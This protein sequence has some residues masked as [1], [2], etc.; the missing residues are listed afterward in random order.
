MKRKDGQSF[1]DYRKERKQR[2]DKISTYLDGRVVFMRGTYNDGRNEA[3]RH[4]R[5][6]KL[7]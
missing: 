4:A 6:L 7:R 5:S 2:E 1:D 3:K